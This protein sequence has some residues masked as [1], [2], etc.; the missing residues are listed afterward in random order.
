MFSRQ[1]GNFKIAF[2]V[3]EIDGVTLLGPIKMWKSLPAEMFAYSRREG[4]F[5]I[6]FQVCEIDKCEIDG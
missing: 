3:C 5:E 6:A 1:E 4:N 2:Q